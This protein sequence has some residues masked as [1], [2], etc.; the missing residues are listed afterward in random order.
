MQQPTQPITLLYAASRGYIDEVKKLINKQSVTQ[1]DDLGNTP[2]RKLRCETWQKLIHP[3]YF[4]PCGSGW[5]F[6]CL[7]GIGEGVSH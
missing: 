4:R 7:H 3:K 2:L 5:S 6:G 1:R